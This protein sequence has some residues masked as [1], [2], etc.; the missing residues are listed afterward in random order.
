MAA[1]HLYSAANQITFSNNQEL[2]PFVGNGFLIVHRGKTYAVTAKHVLF[3]T[4]GSGINSIDIDSYVNDWSLIPFNSNSGKV[5]LGRLLNTDSTEQLD[6]KVL[7]DD[8]LIFDVKEN[9]S[10]LKALNLS[11]SKL[12]ENEEIIAYGC[13]YQNQ[14]DCTQNHYSGRYVKSLNNNL[15]IELNMSKDQ[16]NTLRGLSGAPVVNKDNEVVG[17]VSNIIPDKE[18]DKIY[19]APFSIKSVV[20]FLEKNYQQEYKG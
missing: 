16:L 3:E 7:D 10:K 6:M 20:D 15:L 1:K 13:H 19:F 14:K 11:S 5:V 8:W 17:I 9:S 4:Q 2:K 12:V 18:N